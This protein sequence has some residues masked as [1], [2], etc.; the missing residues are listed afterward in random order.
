V[1]ST[2][3]GTR[4][5]RMSKHASCPGVRTSANPLLPWDRVTSM[6]IVSVRSTSA[7]IDAAANGDGAG[8]ETTR[9]LQSVPRAC[10][11][12]RASSRRCGRAVACQSCL[13]PAY[14]AV[15]ASGGDSALQHLYALLCV[16]CDHGDKA[17]GSTG[18]RHERRT[19]AMPLPCSEQDQ[20]MIARSAVALERAGSAACVSK[21]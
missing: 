21:R 6:R 19:R 13:I 8:F 16:R 20:Q 1:C 14:R 15:S 7:G 17:C 5:G 12:T 11:C 9:L 3:T 10:Q 2:S 4:L 18:L